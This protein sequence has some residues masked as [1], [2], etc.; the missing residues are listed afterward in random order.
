MRSF[1]NMSIPPDLEPS[2]TFWDGI[3]KLADDHDII[4]HQTSEWMATLVRDR[5]PLQVHVF[6]SGDVSSTMANRNPCC[7]TFS[8]VANL[9]GKATVYGLAI[10]VSA[11][12]AQVIFQHPRF[13]PLKEFLLDPSTLKICATPATANEVRELFRGYFRIT[14]PHFRTLVADMAHWSQLMS[15][16]LGQRNLKR[17]IQVQLEG[18]R[19]QVDKTVVSQ[20]I[21]S[22][23]FRLSAASG[24][25]RQDRS[26][27]VVVLLVLHRTMIGVQRGEFQERLRVA[28]G[29]VPRGRRA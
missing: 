8:Y 15:T 29:E 21:T 16:D 27:L 25:T 11:S 3:S 20:A 23:I 28:A 24:L 12:S 6:C 9:A 22:A 4:C 1:E 26:L 19:F 7:I 5:F 2:W 10:Y 17:F 14:I 13:R 18:D